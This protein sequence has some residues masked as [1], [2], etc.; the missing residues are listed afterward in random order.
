MKKRNQTFIK[1]LFNQDQILES[2]IPLLIFN[3]YYFHLS[4]YNV[5]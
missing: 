4:L 2:K 5:L 1:F 3:Y